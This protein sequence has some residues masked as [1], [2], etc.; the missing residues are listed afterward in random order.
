MLQV[1]MLARSIQ[2]ISH[3]EDT[4]VTAA[5]NA[6]GHCG[7]KHGSFIVHGLR[8]VLCWYRVEYELSQEASMVSEMVACPLSSKTE[9]S[10]VTLAYIYTFNHR[11]LQNVSLVL[12]GFK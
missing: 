10:Q 5:D 12:T 7:E 11:Y 4:L 9:H 8:R 6:A 3:W 1:M 2:P